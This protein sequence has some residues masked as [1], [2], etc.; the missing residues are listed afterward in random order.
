MKVLGQIADD[1]EAIHTIRWDI[2]RDL[3]RAVTE[4][5]LASALFALV[6]LGL[7]D[8]FV[9]ESASSKYKRIATDACPV[10]ELWFFISDVG[11]SE[12]ERSS[13]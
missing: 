6:A 5:E 2:E 8:A 3:G 13:V 4:E 1:Y 11:R 9:Y 7:A 10:A 12:Y